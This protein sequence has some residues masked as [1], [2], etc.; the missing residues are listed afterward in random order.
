MAKKNVN[1]L[2]AKID[3]SIALQ[4]RT[5]DN[6]QLSVLNLPVDVLDVDRMLKVCDDLIV[7][8]EGRRDAIVRR[9]EMLNR[10]VEFTTSEFV[11]SHGKEPK[12]RGS[13]MF[14]PAQH[15]NSGDYL[16][17]VVSTPG[18]MTL[19]QAQKFVSQRFIDAGHDTVVVCP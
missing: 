7:L 2:V 5:R 12:G 6:I 14:C 16:D 4:K 9:S 1:A 19:S 10:K 17:H 18:N 11:K 13:W 8:L 3:Q 15:W